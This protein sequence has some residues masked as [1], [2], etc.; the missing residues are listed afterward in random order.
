MN[1]Q[2]SCANTKTKKG[3]EE[4]SYL[5][6]RTFQQNNPVVCAMSETLKKKGSRYKKKNVYQKVLCDSLTFEPV[7]IKFKCHAPPPSC[8]F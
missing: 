2:L 7:F 8:Y 6:I 5:F 4:E 3:F 1:D